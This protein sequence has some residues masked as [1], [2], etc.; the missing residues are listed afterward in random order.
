MRQL[1]IIV[2][3][4][5]MTSCG[6][7]KN[8]VKETKTSEISIFQQWKLESIRGEYLDIN[9]LSKEPQI[10]F[11]KSENRFFGNDGCNSFSGSFKSEGNKIILGPIMA[12]KMACMNMLIPNKYNQALSKVASFNLKQLKGE[13]RQKENYQLQLLDQNSSVILQFV[14]AE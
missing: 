4:F 14:K 7:Q 6:S 1:I 9:A 13:D 12:T 2:I 8:M 5:M 11:D 10:T 3:V